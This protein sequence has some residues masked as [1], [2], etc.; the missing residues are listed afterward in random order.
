MNKIVLELKNLTRS[1]QTSAEI[2]GVLTGID[3]TLKAGET[4]AII[5]QS[6]AGK[7]T[8]LQ[9]AGLLDKPTSGDVIVDGQTASKLK[10]KER[11]KLRGEA[12]GFVYQ[13]HHLLREFTALENVMMPALILGRNESESRERAEMLLEK[14]GLAHR[15][16]HHPSELSGG[17]QQRCAIARALMNKPR[18][19]LAD[20]PTGNLDPHTAD[21]ISKVLWE[22]VKEEN[23]A[24][25][26]V[27]H[28]KE[29]AKSC[30]TAWKMEDGKL[31]KA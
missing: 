16:G 31:V 21:E 1:F 27:T 23:M 18:V 12:L 4:A 3:F 14:V 15:V 20:E 9:I 6:G 19:L 2:V 26:V 24:M 8:L 28:N 29:L 10:D 17:E 22:T 7:S 11:S 25:L 30:D 13:S 5:G